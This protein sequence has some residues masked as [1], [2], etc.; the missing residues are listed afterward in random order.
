[1]R[2]LTRWIFGATA[3]F[4]LLL[5]TTPHTVRAQEIDEEAAEASLMKADRAMSEAQATSNS[6]LETFMAHATDDVTVLAPDTPMAQGKEAAR[7]IFAKMYSMPG[8]ALTW[9]PTTADVSGDLG[10][11]IGTY[12]MEFEG[13]EGRSVALDGKYMTI[14][15]KQPDG[16]WKLA[17]DMFNENGPPEPVEEEGS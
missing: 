8:F 13:P 5:A 4:L 11:T 12:H 9:E 15:E 16:T 6:P 7:P 3:G 17:V 10:Y 1:M 14:W 2:T